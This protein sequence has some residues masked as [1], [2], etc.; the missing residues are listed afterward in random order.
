REYAVASL[1]RAPVRAHA[2][3]GDHPAQLLGG[4]ALTR[5][6]GPRGDREFA[7]QHGHVLVEERPQVDRHR[8]RRARRGAVAVRIPALGA[9]GPACADRFGEPLVRPA[10]PRDALERLSGV[11]RDA[12]AR[13][14]APAPE[15]L[16]TL[17]DAREALLDEVLRLVG[18]PPHAAE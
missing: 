5:L 17:D 14:H 10:K 7:E 6:L 8:R 18:D 13:G 12:I 3:V 15:V 4:L 11:R 16:R 2:D 1:E 9:A